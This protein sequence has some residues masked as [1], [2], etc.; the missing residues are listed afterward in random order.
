MNPL[1]IS[2]VVC[3][4][5]LLP[6]LLLTYLWHYKYHLYNSLFNRVTY[7][8]VFIYLEMTTNVILKKYALKHFYFYL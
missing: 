4:V 1:L 3:E 5:F 7:F 2:W 6:N 8:A